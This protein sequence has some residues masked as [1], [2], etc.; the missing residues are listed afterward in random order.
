MK[1]TSVLNVIYFFNYQLT[2]SFKTYV[3]QIKHLKRNHV[4]HDCVWIAKTKLQL[5]IDLIWL[6]YLTVNILPQ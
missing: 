2:F 4:D 3:T 6:S 1:K 5:P